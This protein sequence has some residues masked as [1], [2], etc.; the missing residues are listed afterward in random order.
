MKPLTWFDV[1]DHV[2]RVWHVLLSCDAD[3]PEL[4]RA[5]DGARLAGLTM[6]GRRVV[7]I[8]AW[9]PRDE[10]DRAVIHEFAHIAFNHDT[11]PTP[12]EERVI[13]RSTEELLPLLRQIG[14]R[15][16][17]RPAG[18]AALERRARGDFHPEEEDAD[19]PHSDE[20]CDA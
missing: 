2:G 6:F 16:P 10:Q 20:E 14:L 12:A 8:N 4:T 7:F 5:S 19:P 15:I 11:D 17:R 3:E 13:T 18:A 1:T 9:C